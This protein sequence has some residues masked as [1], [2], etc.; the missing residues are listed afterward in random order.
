[1]YNYIQYILYSDLIIFITQYYYINFAYYWYH[2]IL[3]QPWSGILYEKHYLCHHKKDYPLRKIRKYEYLE[4]NGSNIIF[5]APIFLTI[6]LNYYLFSYRVFMYYLLNISFI[7]ITGEVFH[8]SYHLFN[9]AKS[10][11]DV[12]IIVHKFITKLPIYN[13]LRN[14][15][16]IHHARKD[17]NFGFIDFQM[18]R[19]FGTF[20][21]KSPKY[22]S[23]IQNKLNELDI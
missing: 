11:P 20:D 5:G 19:I 8:S 16:D 22:L 17:T 12:P 21:E 9:N 23:N 13:Y 15:H 3:H 14:M 1:M 7:A 4:S 10:H 6:L 2:W 18:D